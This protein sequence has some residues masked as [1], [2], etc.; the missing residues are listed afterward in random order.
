[1][2]AIAD[3]V[4]YRN[5]F[6][7]VAFAEFTELRDARHGAVLIHDFADDAT[8]PQSGDPGQI[9]DGFGLARAHQDS[10]FTRAQGE[11]M[12]GPREVTGFRTRVNGDLNGAGTIGRR[13]SGGD[14]FARFN[15]FA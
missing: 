3:E 1:M 11:D 14:A 9:D 4:G 7:S 15:G 8:G 2:E 13:D 10:P 6:E 12:T 5:H